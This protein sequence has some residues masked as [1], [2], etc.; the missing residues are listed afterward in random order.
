V[1]RYR[2]TAVHTQTVTVST[3]AGPVQRPIIVIYEVR[4]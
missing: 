2:G 3:A 1:R 4:P